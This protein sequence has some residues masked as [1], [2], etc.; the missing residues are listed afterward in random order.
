[1]DRLAGVIEPTLVVAL[2][3]TNMPG[4]DDLQLRGEI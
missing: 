2:S 4:V 1:L 3:D